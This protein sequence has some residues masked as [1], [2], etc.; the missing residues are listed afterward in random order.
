MKPSKTA[1]FYYLLGFIV[2]LVEM[3][4]SML[5]KN[6]L[7]YFNFGLGILCLMWV[8]GMMTDL[9]RK[10]KPKNDEG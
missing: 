8:V 4:V 6:D 7:T 9:Y 10:E 2:M 3:I 5:N 1:L